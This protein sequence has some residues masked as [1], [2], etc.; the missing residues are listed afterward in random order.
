MNAAERPARPAGMGFTIGLGIA[1]ALGIILTMYLLM[2][3]WG[4]ASW[5]FGLIVSVVM[6]A[7]ALLRDGH[8]AQTAAVGLAVTVAAVVVS[9]AVGGD[10]PQEPAPVSALA[11][12]VLVGSAIRTLRRG[13]AALIA[14]GG[15]GVTALI[16]VDGWSLV[17]ILATMGMLAAFVLGSVL[18]VLDRRRHANAP[19]AHVPWSAAPRS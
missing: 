16:W 19:A 18:R 12:S 7:L 9:L 5:V 4:G 14:V 1:F 2:H 17:T 11:L 8:R 6:S 13:P 10:L 3:S 15:G